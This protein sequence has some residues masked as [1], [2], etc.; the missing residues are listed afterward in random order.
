MD[1]V[2][3]ESIEVLSDVIDVSSA[4]EVVFMDSW[5]ILTSGHSELG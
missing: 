4:V 2:P 5:H 3:V 1:L